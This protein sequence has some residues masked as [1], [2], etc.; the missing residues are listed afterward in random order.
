MTNYRDKAQSKASFLEIARSKPE[1]EGFGQILDAIGTHLGLLG[2]AA[3]FEVERNFQDSYLST[4]LTRPAVLAASYDRNYVPRKAIPSGGPIR[5]VN[6]SKTETHSVPSGMALLSADDYYYETVMPIAVEP[7][8]NVLV[9]SYQIERLTLSHTIASEHPFYE[10]RIDPVVSRRIHKISVFV[11]DIEWTE[12]KNFRDTD[13]FTKCW[14]EFYTELDQLGVRFGNGTYGKIPALDSTVR[15]GL[16]LTDGDITLLSSNSLSPE[17]GVT[18][19]LTFITGTIIENGSSMEGTEETRRNA[20]YYF[21]YDEKHEWSNDYRFMLKQLFPEMLFCQVWGEEKQERMVGF[22]AVEHISHIFFSVYETGRTTLPDEVLE[23]LSSI[24]E[25]NRY[26]THKPVEFKKFTVDISGVINHSLVL[27]DI[28]IR[29]QEL[30][31]RDY[32]QDS[33]TRKNSALKRDIYKLMNSMKVNGV[34]VFKSED[35]I[36]VFLSGDTE[37]AVSDQG[38]PLLYEMIS[39]DIDITRDIHLSYPKRTGYEL[40]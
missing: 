17:N 36:E 24:P 25:Y 5:V 1:L 11:D 20:L 19:D 12:T 2:E 40:G 16:I 10:I 18:S 30:L 22:R 3:H 34:K 4:A 28:E 23:A 8:A 21:L 14:A 33:K 38:Q 39:I 27:T 29:I 6:N 13:E 7:G 35:D 15:L 37:P 31:L 32:G 26:F 9:N